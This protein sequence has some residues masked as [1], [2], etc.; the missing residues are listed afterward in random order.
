MA[1]GHLKLLPDSKCNKLCNIVLICLGA[2]RTV[3]ASY[4]KIVISPL[5]DMLQILA[6]LTNP[7]CSPVKLGDQE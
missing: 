3:L 5:C 4:L 7:K 1:Q 2:H 6:N